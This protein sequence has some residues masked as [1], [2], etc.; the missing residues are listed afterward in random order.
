MIRNGQCRFHEFF[1]INY[2]RM[3]FLSIVAAG[4]L[5]LSA[6]GL[7]A[8]EANAPGPLKNRSDSVAYA[9]GASIARDL[10]RTG[11]EELNATVLAQAVTDVFAGKETTFDETAERALIMEAITAARTKMD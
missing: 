3:K 5:M 9:F 7:Y 8:Q 6:T 10:K 11:V 1:K 2:F 4:S